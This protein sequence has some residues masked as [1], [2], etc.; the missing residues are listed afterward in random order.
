[1]VLIATKT[2]QQ[3]EKFFMKKRVTAA[4]FSVFLSVSCIHETE[5][6]QAIEAEHARSAGVV[7]YREHVQP[8]L[9]A[10]CSACHGSEAAHTIYAFNEEPERWM[11]QGQAM[12]MDTYSHLV[13]YIVWPDT[14]AFM[15]RLDDGTTSQEGKP[16]N[17]Y[18]YLGTTEEERQQNLQILKDW[19]GNWNLK[20]WKEVSKEELVELEL[21][22]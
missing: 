4:L 12:R 13:A 15:R 11:A 14:G 1:M 5:G 9:A 22:Y 17:M 16:G 3:Q 20:R 7:T 8:L 2:T 18:I 21:K 10:R 6:N 19:V